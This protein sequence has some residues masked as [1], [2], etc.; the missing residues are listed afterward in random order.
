MQKKKGI[1]LIVLVITIIVMVILAGAIIL[2]L[3]NSGIIGKASEA[4][5]ETNLTTTKE[6]ASLAWAEAYMDGVREVE[7]EDGFEARIEDALKNNNVD[8]SK[9]ILEITTSGVTVKIKPIITWLKTSEG[10]LAIGSTVKTSTNEE[11]YV[12]GGDTVGTPITNSTEKVILLAKNNLKEDG[13]VQDP[14]GAINVCAF[15][16]VENLSFTDEENLNN[17]TTVKADTTSAVYKAM[18]YGKMLGATTGRLMLYSEVERLNETDI[19]SDIM[20]GV[21]GKSSGEYLDY[22]LGTANGTTTVSSVDGSCL[23]F[24]GVCDYRGDNVYIRSASNC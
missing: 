16:T 5:E 6:V 21:N 24:G 23:I 11:F 8:Q 10:E 22:W 12:I 18:K 15:S 7:G 4:V 20:Y 17:N 13:S 9:Y 19:G 14:T 3:N 2:T 1:S